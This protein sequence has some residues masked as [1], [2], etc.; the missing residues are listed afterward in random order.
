MKHD[1]LMHA[2]AVSPQESCG[3]VL[4]NG[5]Y[6]R[7]NNIAPLPEQHCQWPASDWI[8]ASKIAA[9]AA[10]VHSHPQGMRCLS[11]ADRQNQLVTQLPWHL[12]VD[13]EVLTFPCVPPL[14][15][16]KFQHQHSDCYS[17]I[18]DAYALTGV[19]L[20]DFEREEEWW[21]KGGDLYLENVEKAGFHQIDMADLQLGDVILMKIASKKVN[22]G[23]VYLGDETLIHHCDRRL[24]KRDPYGGAWVRSTHSCWRHNLWQQL[25]FT[26]ILND[27]VLS[28]S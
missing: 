3:F 19:I 20:P 11:L 25:D 18:Q 5:Q 17:L 8:R 13:G 15:H 26:G 21:D 9:V 28:T 4:S 7:C 16:R 22:H 2:Q 1:A 12:V 10:L 27:L 6:F 24:S 14:L 23:A